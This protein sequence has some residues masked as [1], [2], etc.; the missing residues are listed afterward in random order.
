M[1]WQRIFHGYGARLENAGR[2]QSVYEFTLSQFPTQIVRIKVIE[3]PEGRYHALADHCITCDADAG[4]GRPVEQISP[5]LALKEALEA[6]V[7]QAE[8]SPTGRLQRMQYW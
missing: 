2:V 1:Q 3:T 7:R 8:G 5:E 6:L 4:W